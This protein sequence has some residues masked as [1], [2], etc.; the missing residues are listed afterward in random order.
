MQTHIAN[1]R[2]TGEEKKVKKKS[3]CEACDIYQLVW[4]EL[5]NTCFIFIQAFKYIQLLFSL[6]QASPSFFQPQPTSPILAR[7]VSWVVRLT[8]NLRRGST[9]Q[10]ENSFEPF[11]K[12]MSRNTDFFHTNQNRWHRRAKTLKL[13]ISYVLD[14]LCINAATCT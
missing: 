6:N 7:S 10:M 13:L 11:P 1:K 5:S 2:Q 12:V 9:T 4:K 8:L 3:I 14:Y